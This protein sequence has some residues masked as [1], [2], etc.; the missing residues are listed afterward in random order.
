MPDFIALDWEHL[1][2]CGLD[3]EVTAAGVRVHQAFTLTWPEGKSPDV[4]ALAAGGWLHEQFQSLGLTAKS[5]LVTVPREDAVVR[6][7][8]VPDVPDAELPDVV[9]FQ[10]AAKS[11]RPL[12]TQLLDYLPLPRREGAA[13]G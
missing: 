4:D 6:V 1:Q 13:G 5:V 10:A 12:D 8:E 9:R 7:L 3:A 2:V 11:T